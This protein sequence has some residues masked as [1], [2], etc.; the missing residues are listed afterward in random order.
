MNTLPNPSD[1][2]ELLEVAMGSALYTDLLVQLEKDFKLASE[3]FDCPPTLEPSAL[4]AQLAH[5]IHH[6]IQHK[7]AE[8]LNLLYIFDVPEQAFKQL[9][10]NDLMELSEDLGFL[11]L[12]REWMK[13]W[14]RKNWK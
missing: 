3:D 5:R 11:I 10:G 7:Y 9:D 6:L 1:T 4:K 13:V 14:Y 2:D 12:R 8:L